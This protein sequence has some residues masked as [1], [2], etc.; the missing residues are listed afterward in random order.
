MTRKKPIAKQ[1]EYNKFQRDF[2]KNHNERTRAAC[3]KA[4]KLV[5]SAPGGSSYK[6]YLILEAQ[7]DSNSN[8]D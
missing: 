3:N 1:F 5:K 2:Y 8:I 7:N 6:N 4:W